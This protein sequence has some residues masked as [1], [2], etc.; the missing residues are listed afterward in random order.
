MD[1]VYLDP[2][3]E[4]ARRRT[5]LFDGQIFLFT[6]RPAAMALV[7]HARSMVEEGFGGL[8][9]ETAQDH[10]SVEEYAQLLADLKPKFIHH[11]RSKELIAALMADLGCNPERTYFDVPRLRTS[12][13]G[14]Y[15][16]T[17][18][19][20]AFHP[21]RDCWYSAPFSQQ[22][23]WMPVYDV[24]RDNVVA[25][26]PHYWTHPVRNGSRD[27]NYAEWNRVSRYNAA[28]QIGEDTRKQPKAEEELELDPQ[29][30]P[31]MPPGG[32]MLFSGAQ[33][34]SSVPNTSGRTRISID[35]RTVNIDD[36]KSGAGAPNI[37]AECTGTT[38]GDFLRCSDLEHLP[39]ELIARYDTPPAA[40]P[41]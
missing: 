18:I 19:A 23:W 38:L 12:T 21:H 11:P 30:R 15:L 3:F 31:V 39:E 24:S 6:P 36:V 22:N 41:A 17:G 37:D 1:T 10:M 28:Q 32:L 34:H 35:F 33:L 16:T 7:E 27:Y 2:A 26:H 5:E 14:G 4:D 8:D 9:P 13:S 29:I 20:Y 40:T 25:F